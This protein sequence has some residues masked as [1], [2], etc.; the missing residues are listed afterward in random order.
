MP[1][2]SCFLLFFAGLRIFQV[3]GNRCSWTDE[4]R[5]L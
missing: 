5:I 2:A 3:R 4:I 1:R